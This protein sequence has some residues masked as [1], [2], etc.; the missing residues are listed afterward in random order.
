MMLSKQDIVKMHAS[1]LS[2]GGRPTTPMPPLAGA[3]EMILADGTE[4]A[5]NILLLDI[6]LAN[7]KAPTGY[8]LPRWTTIQCGVVPDNPSGGQPKRISGPWIRKM[9]FTATVPNGRNDFH[10]FD[11]QPGIDRL[12]RCSS[13]VQLDPN[14]RMPQAFRPVKPVQDP[15]NY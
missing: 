13:E 2:N 8:I 3:A 9:L 14:D 7:P 15:Y 5:L 4:A 11:T 12:H 1:H 6:N 10:V